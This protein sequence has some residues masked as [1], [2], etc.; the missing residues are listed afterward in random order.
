MKAYEFATQVDD[1][2]TSSDVTSDSLVVIHDG[3]GREIPILGLSVQYDD[4][5]HAFIVVEGQVN[6]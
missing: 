3:S 6:G 5:G 4:D 1:V 2:T